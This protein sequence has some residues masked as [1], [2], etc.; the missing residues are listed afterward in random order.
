MGDAYLLIET[1]GGE[2]A[3]GKC[4]HILRFNVDDIEQALADVKT[5]GIDAA[6]ESHDWGDTINILDPDGNQ[7]SIRDEAGFKLQAN[8][9]NKFT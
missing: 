2:Q 6:I 5:Y 7:I 8:L 1:D 9:P 4:P 3:A